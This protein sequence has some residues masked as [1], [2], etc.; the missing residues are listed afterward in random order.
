MKLSSKT[1]ACFPMFAVCLMN[2]NS[3]IH[4]DTVCAVSRNMLGLVCG[5]QWTCHILNE[6]F[7]APEF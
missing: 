3:F 6:F 7:Q 1:G 4:E 5:F 2:Y